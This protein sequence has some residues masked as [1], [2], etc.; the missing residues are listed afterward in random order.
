[1]KMLCYTGKIGV[2]ACERGG[3]EGERER[4]RERFWFRSGRTIYLCWSIFRYFRFYCQTFE[5]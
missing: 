2:R 4:E 1:M 5:K 3:K